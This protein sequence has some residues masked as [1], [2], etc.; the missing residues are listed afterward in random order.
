[1]KQIF[2]R[3]WFATDKLF[4]SR[5]RL[6]NFSD[7]GSLSIEAGQLQ[8]G[9]RKRLIKSNAIKSIDLV[10]AHVP[11]ISIG[12][13]FI[14]LIIFLGFW[15]SSSREPMEISLMVVP[16]FFILLPSIILVQK[17]MLWIEIVFLDDDNI[18][19]R[20]Y[21]LDG[22]RLGWGGIF[23]G[24]LEMYKKMKSVEESAG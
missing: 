17:V 2:P 19:R 21:F 18:L 13:T 1:M 8:F 3:V 23:G 12:L 16:F 10:Y 6:I 15:V 7:Y 22:S 9:G 20:A 24:T 14:A 5:T 11:W 4:N